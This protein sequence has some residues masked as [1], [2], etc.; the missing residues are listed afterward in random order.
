VA[1]GSPD[2]WARTIGEIPLTFLD[3]TDTPA[4]YTGQA[5][6]AVLVKS[7]EDG[8]EFGA[9]GVAFSVI[10]VLGTL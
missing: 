1:Y 4:L 10:A 3:L 2:W 8:L 6:K 5:E 7:T 9:G